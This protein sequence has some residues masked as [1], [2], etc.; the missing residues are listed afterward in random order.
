M[1]QDSQVFVNLS[2]LTVLPQQTPEHTLP[3]HPLHL[4]RHTCLGG[5]LPLSVSGVTTL[6]L[7][8]MEIASSCTRVDS[9]GFNDNTAVLDELFD[10]GARVGIADLCLL[11]GVEPD[12]S[13][14]D[15]CDGGGE[16]LLG[17]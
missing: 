16:P 13:L 1:I 6:A 9:G 2:S 17:P 7:R 11:S 4:R 8:G 15:T 14:A 12:L 5:T 10:M 3:P